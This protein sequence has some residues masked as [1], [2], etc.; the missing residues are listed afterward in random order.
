MTGSSSTAVVA[1]SPTSASRPTTR[2]TPTR[3]SA[4][5][6]RW[7]STARRS[8]R[9]SSTGT[10]TP[11]DSFI[12]PV[13]DGYREDACEYCDLDAERGQRAAR[14]GRLRPQPAGR[15]VVQRRRRARRVDGG[16]G[17]PAAAEPGVEF[18]LQ[19]NLDFAEYLP[20]RRREGLDRSVPARLEHGLPEPGEL[21]GRRCTR[22]A[23]PPAGSNYGFYDN[24]EF[25]ALIA[26]GNQAATS[27]EAI[28][29]YQQAEDLIVEDMPSAPLFF[30][31]DQSV[32]SENVETSRST[33]SGA[34][35]SP[36]SPSSADRPDRP[37]DPP[38]ALS[39]AG[40]RPRRRG[41]LHDGRR[42]MD[43][44]R[45]QTAVAPRD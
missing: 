21:P 12:A 22:R 31:R 37:H 34:S 3:G 38:G 40:S 45:P 35:T 5:P 7:R 16:R 11:A 33:S 23:L 26:Q 39:H 42:T 20:L 18:T 4:R 8:P 17:Q 10:R 15:P 1:D 44:S 36:R 13:V 27:E 19:G 25:D 24:P 32:H 29:V 43:P 28:A 6:S 9:P 14:R 30:S 41:V 2:A